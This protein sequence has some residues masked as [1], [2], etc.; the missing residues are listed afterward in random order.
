MEKSSNVTSVDEF[1][2]RIGI[3]KNYNLVNGIHVH[4]DL[5]E[6]LDQK[7]YRYTS[8]EYLLNMI[9]SG[10]LYVSRRTKFDDKREVGKKTDLRNSFHMLPADSTKEEIERELEWSKKCANKFFNSFVSCWT[11]GFSEGDSAE[12]YLMW[13]AYGD[14]RVGC[15]VETT[16]RKLIES[17]KVDENVMVFLADVKYIARER[18]ADSS[19][20][21]NVFEKDVCFSDERELR[22][23]IIDNSSEDQKTHVCG[24][25]YHLDVNVKKND[26][27][28]NNFAFHFK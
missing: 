2:R 14:N 26:S 17:I 21:H 7:I 24:D 6:K 22:I 28:N 18:I 23:C 10:K 1:C 11:Y 9:K 12:S 3:Y 13:K 15:R 20:E 25:S 4:N 5:F 16:V 8:F 19:I 27:G